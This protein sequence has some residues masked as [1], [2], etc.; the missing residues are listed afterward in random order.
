MLAVA[1]AGSALLQACASVATGKFVPTRSENLNHSVLPT[2]R[3]ES[4]HYR[5]S[6]AT[7]S[8]MQTTSGKGGF[9]DHV[10]Y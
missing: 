7:H 6:P 5:A 3:N 10:Y 9:W 1:V 4:F 2:Y 8:M